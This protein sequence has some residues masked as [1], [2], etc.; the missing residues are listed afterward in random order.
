ML[1][2]LE[3]KKKPLSHEVCSNN[4]FTFYDLKKSQQ[5]KWKSLGLRG[6]ETMFW[7]TGGQNTSHKK[8]W[9][10]STN[11]MARKISA[12]NGWNA[13]AV[14]VIKSQHTTRSF[15]AGQSAALQK[16]INLKQTDFWRHG[17]FRFC[18]TPRDWLVK[19]VVAG[20]IEST[21]CSTKQV[22]RLEWVG[23]LAVD[24]FWHEVCICWSME[25]NCWENARF[26]ST[27]CRKK[28]FHSKESDA[29]NLRSIFFERNLFTAKNR[30]LR[31]YGAYTR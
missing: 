25:C 4:F 19:Y 29:R 30:T 24:E 5:K 12:L 1:R 27:L 28:S 10:D 2:N 20:E 8:R 15:A 11:L 26:V 13:N 18:Q 31:T 9:K 6:T 17:K 23:Q 16:S 22:L 3:C 14:H 21:D 7:I